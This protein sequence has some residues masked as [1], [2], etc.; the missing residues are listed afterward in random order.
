MAIYTIHNYDKKTSIPF[1]DVAIKKV[2]KMVGNRNRD[3][4]DY[5]IKVWEQLENKKWCE[6]ELDLV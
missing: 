6:A 3:L 5:Y 1:N 4:R 2:I